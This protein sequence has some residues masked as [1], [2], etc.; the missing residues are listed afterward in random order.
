[1]G[2]FCANANAR[3]LPKTAPCFSFYLSY[4]RYSPA[5][6]TPLPPPCFNFLRYVG[7]N[8]AMDL[9]GVV[10][11]SPDSERDLASARKSA[12][13]LIDAMVTCH[14]RDSRPR[15][16]AAAVLFF[17]APLAPASCTS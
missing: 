7:R 3:M 12:L 4:F 9:E 10:D 14:I 11:L 2:T 17:S 16:E 15:E 8:L 6:P 5:P 13:H 1:M